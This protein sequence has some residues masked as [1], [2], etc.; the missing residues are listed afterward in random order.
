MHKNNDL[1][2]EVWTSGEILYKIN[3]SG[4]KIAYVTKLSDG[5]V[6]HYFKEPHGMD[7]MLTAEMKVEAANALKEVSA[8]AYAVMCGVL[9][10]EEKMNIGFQQSTSQA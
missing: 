2:F 6:R 3:V 9:S 5:H 8:N 1:L 10:D 4:G 7:W